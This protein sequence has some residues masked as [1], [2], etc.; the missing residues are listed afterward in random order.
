MLNLNQEKFSQIVQTAL[1]HISDSKRWRNAIV[2][3]AVEIEV[4]PFM[5]WKDGALLI[6]SPSNEIY[7]AN[8]TCQCKAFASGQPCWHRAAARLIE[9]Y[10]ETSH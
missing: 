3:A 8:G 4:N 6:L 5:E 9:R 1:A 7:E 2:R 10:N